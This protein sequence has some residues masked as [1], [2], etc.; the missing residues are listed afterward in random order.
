M[1]EG[2]F[3]MSEY[4]YLHVHDM[5][6]LSIARYICMTCNLLMDFVIA[7]VN[8]LNGNWGAKANKPNIV[9]TDA[10]DKRTDKYVNLY[11]L[12]QAKVCPA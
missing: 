3:P 11:K 8:E 9:Q 6:R 4:R 7:Y 5:F 1:I 12:I 2:V 10:P